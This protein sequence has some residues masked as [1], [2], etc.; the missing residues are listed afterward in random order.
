MSERKSK[1]FELCRDYNTFTCSLLCFCDCGCRGGAG[2]F[3]DW[4]KSSKERVDRSVLML[5]QEKVKEEEEN[6]PPFPS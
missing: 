1:A 5:L 3:F 4:K 2:E 6:Q